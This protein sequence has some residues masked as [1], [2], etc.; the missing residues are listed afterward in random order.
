MAIDH[1]PITRRQWTILVVY[2]FV[3]LIVSLIITF[4]AGIPPIEVALPSVP[5][6]AFAAISVVLITA[7]HTWVMTH[8]EITRARYGLFASPEEAEEA[9]RD[10]PPTK[11][12]ELQRSHAA[13]RN[14]SENT[15]IFALALPIFVL[16]TPPN[17]LAG[18]WLVGYGAARLGHT[19][20]F[21][22][23]NASIRG[24]F[25]TLSLIALYGIVLYPALSSLFMLV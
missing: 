4:V 2:P 3:P 7:N 20:F 23:G 18:L 16:L 13:H 12:P 9:D 11:H 19:F 15:V 8:T 22:S 25:M 1:P 6:V 5:I 24:V 14:L 17:L 10:L 21:L